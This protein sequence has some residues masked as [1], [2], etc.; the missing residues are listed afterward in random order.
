MAI[1][2]EELVIP[3]T[4]VLEFPLVNNGLL[5]NSGLAMIK[6][7][8]TDGKEAV[9][10][11]TGAANE[12]FAGISLSDKHLTDTG[13]VVAY[14][15]TVPAASPYTVQ[16]PHTLEVSQ[17]FAAETDGTAL[18]TAATVSS[19]GLVTFAAG[20][21]GKDVYIQYSYKLSYHQKQWAS[22]NPYPSAT[23]D[24]NQVP[25]ATGRCRV[26]TSSFVASVAWALY[27]DVRLGAN[28]ELTNTGSGTVIGKVYKVPAADD[29]F[30]GVEYTV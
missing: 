3:N 9:S 12:V 17:V 23:D 24:L 6:V 18:G 19:T 11:C 14:P 8:G 5:A 7:T 29:Y 10:P 27:D 20:D 28:G 16:L 15:A 13:K 4:G 21:A 1:N 22:V 30:L 25:V 2:F 26:P